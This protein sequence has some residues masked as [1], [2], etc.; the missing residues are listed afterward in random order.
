MGSVANLNQR[1]TLE[2]LDVFAQ[3]VAPLIVQLQL[4]IQRLSATVD[5]FGSVAAERL[6]TSVDEFFKA[7]SYRRVEIGASIALGLWLHQMW[8]SAQAARHEEEKSDRW[9]KAI[10]AGQN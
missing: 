6:G 10:T 4:D 1:R 5:A 7:V 9:R 8:L 3:Q 2:Q